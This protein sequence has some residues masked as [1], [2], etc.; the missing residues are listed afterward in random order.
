[1]RCWS[2]RVFNLSKHVRCSVMSPP[3]PETDIQDEAAASP[4]DLLMDSTSQSERPR[5]QITL[6]VGTLF[7]AFAGAPIAA[8]IATICA[9]LA[10]NADYAGQTALLAM[11]FGM[12]LGGVVGFIQRTRNSTSSNRASQPGLA[13]CLAS[14]RLW[15]AFWER[16]GSPEAR[17]RYSFPWESSSSVPPLACWSAG[18]W[19]ARSSR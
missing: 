4:R 9:W 8:V 5:R 6:F 18:S 17:S 10:D 15:P 11:P 1:M 16:S 3:P 7:G 2:M 14:C 19:I 13:S 12:L